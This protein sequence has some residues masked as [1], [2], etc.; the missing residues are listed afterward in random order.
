MLLST[1]LLLVLLW[2]IRWTWV[3]VWRLEVLFKLPCWWYV[4]VRGVVYACMDVC[5]SAI[6]YC[7]RDLKKLTLT[8]H[9]FSPSFPF[10]FSFVQIPFLVILGWIIGQPMTLY[11]YTFETVMLFISVIIVN[12]VIVDGESHWLEGTFLLGKWLVFFLLCLCFRIC[13]TKW[14]LSFGLF[15]FLSFRFVSR[16]VSRTSFVGSYLLIFLTQAHTSALLLASTTT[17]KQR[18]KKQTRHRLP[19]P[20]CSLFISGCT[21]AA[22][23]WRSFTITIIVTKM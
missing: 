3:S 19:C 22:F 16:F 15:R 4:S 14:L 21:S 1:W 8:W 7:C 2:K 23:F 11:F 6:F 12:A 18:M 9:W 10:S 17:N 13:G 20:P 5:A